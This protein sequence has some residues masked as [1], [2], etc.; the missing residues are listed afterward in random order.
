ML[1]LLSLLVTVCHATKSSLMAMEPHIFNSIMSEANPEGTQKNLDDIMIL[2]GTGEKER[3]V[4]IHNQSVA[5]G[6][7]DDALGVWQ[8]AYDAEQAALGVQKTAEKA[9]EMATQARDEAIK[10]R[11][12]KIQEKKVA[13]DRVP[14]AKKFME[15]EIARVKSEHE[16]LNKVKNILE[17]LLPKSVIETSSRKLL[18]RM[19][20]LLSNPTFLEQLK[21]AN[22]TAVQQVIDMVVGLINKGE[23][24]RQSAIDKYNARVA[25]AA[26]AA[27]NLLDA[28][29]DLEDK[30][31]K[32]KAA[33]ANRIAKTKIAEAATAVEVEKRK[34]RDAKKNKLEVQKE[35]TA[36][37]IKRIDFEKAI[38]EEGHS[39]ESLLKE[40]L[41]VLQD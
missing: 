36:R 26:Q 3:A 8:K 18:S 6:I 41:L 37:E 22:P 38:L 35:F 31:E 5:Q 28:E 20:T 7:Y 2:I 21:K 14:V 16:T 29:A 24:E 39:Q 23:E 12:I 19:A 34:I 11:D 10:T 30:E 1:F 13:D 15:D 4:A 17:G 33:T 9:E 32:L 25:E 40:V 27:Q